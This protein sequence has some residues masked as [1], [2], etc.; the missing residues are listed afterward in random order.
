MRRSG[1]RTPAR[2]NFRQLE[3]D[4]KARFCFKNNEQ[5]GSIIIDAHS[6]TR[7]RILKRIAVDNHV[8]TLVEA[9]DLGS[10]V[11]EKIGIR[12][13]ASVFQGFCNLHD[14]EIFHDIDDSDYV[15]GN[16]KQEFLFAYRAIAKE[17]HAKVESINITEKRLNAA[18]NG[19]INMLSKYENDIGFMYDSK[20]K[21]EFINRRKKYLELLNWH[22]ERYDIYRNLL[23]GYL[24]NQRYDR[25]HTFRI[26]FAGEYPITTSSIFQIY[27]DVK[28]HQIYNGNLIKPVI[29]TVFPQN[30]T[31]Y[32]LIS[33]FTKDKYYYRY[34]EEQIIKSDET[35]QKRIISNMICC[36]VENFFLSPSLWDSYDEQTKQKICDIS[37]LT[38]TKGKPKYLGYFDINFFV[39]LRYEVR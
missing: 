6:I 35:T 19:D 8:C 36:Y 1:K 11:M 22:M 13:E 10:L 9:K 24:N 5:C 26:E 32:V 31:T 34:I 2:S 17:Y 23:N 28:G 39:D 29:L 33:C 3:R 27:F 4:S 12:K 15:P 37:Y 18:I 16:L 14:N 30:G 38:I 7:N 25:M 20:Q 21:N